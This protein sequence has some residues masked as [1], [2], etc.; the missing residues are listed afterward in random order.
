[1]RSLTLGQSLTFP[2]SAEDPDIA[3][4]YD[5]PQCAAFDLETDPTAA[6]AIHVEWTGTTPL[7]VSLVGCTPLEDPYPAGEAHGNAGDNEVTL[8][9]PDAW[10]AQSSCRPYIQIGRALGTAPFIDPIT[11][12]VTVA[13]SGSAALGSLVAIAPAV[14]AG[15]SGRP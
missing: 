12:R 7:G 5:C 6:W 2:L 15:S 8:T 14:R 9:M 13:A 4:I 11:V 3:Y 1:M 10:T